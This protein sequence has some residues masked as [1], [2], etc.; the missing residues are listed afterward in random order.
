MSSSQCST[1]ARQTVISLSLSDTSAAHFRHL[2]AEG[3]IAIK[4]APFVMA[5]AQ[6]ALT[7]T[8][9]SIGEV[10]SVRTLQRSFQRLG[11][12]DKVD[13]AEEFQMTKS[14]RKE[15]KLYLLTPLICHRLITHDIK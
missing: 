9:P 6:T 12:R 1:F 7:G 8:A 3:K 5:L 10:I 2:T 13:I 11:E 4:N 14:L 15:T